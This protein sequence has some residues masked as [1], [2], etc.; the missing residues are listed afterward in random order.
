MLAHTCV[1][2][3]DELIPE[4]PEAAILL[5]ADLS[6]QQIHYVEQGQIRDSQ[7]ISSSQYGNGNEVDSLRSPLGWHRV[8]EIIGRD[9]P[10]GQR[11]VSRRPVG[12]P[13]REW[14]GGSED[15]I[16][17]RILRLEGLVPELNGLSYQRYIYIHGTNQEEKLG[18]AASHGCLRMANLP[19]LRWV[20]WLQDQT[21]YVWI[22][23]Q[24]TQRIE[25]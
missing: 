12:Q 10:A 20:D 9:Q 22:G 21:C 11:F 23:Q 1:Q 8:C 7:H 19:L 2:S 5:C 16:L 17:S 3:I 6:R 14:T 25:I 15:A 18:S 4:L 13:L 24:I